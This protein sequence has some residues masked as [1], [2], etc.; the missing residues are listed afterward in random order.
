MRIRHRNLLETWI[1]DPQKA[2]WTQM[3]LIKLESLDHILHRCGIVIY[4]CPLSSLEID[5]D[6]I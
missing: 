1:F 6:E 4:H 2:Q 3:W 5:V